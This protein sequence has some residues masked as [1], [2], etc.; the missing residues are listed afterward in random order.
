MLRWLLRHVPETEPAKLQ[1]LTIPLGPSQGAEARTVRMSILECVG[2]ETRMR[3]TISISITITTVIPYSIANSN[4][5]HFCSSKTLRIWMTLSSKASDKWFGF[6]GV[7]RLIFF[8]AGVSQ[9]YGSRWQLLEPT[10][11]IFV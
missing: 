2:T 8:C 4:F 3:G 9:F 7:L 5:Q 6:R 11:F 10:V 1:R